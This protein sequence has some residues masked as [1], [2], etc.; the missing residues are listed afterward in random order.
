MSIQAR[1]IA[2]QARQIHEADR[3]ARFIALRI[4][5]S[6]CTVDEVNVGVESW[7]VVGCESPLAVRDAMR[8]L[9]QAPTQVVL[10]YGGD[11]S[12]LGADVLG[13]CAK[14]K[15]F[16]PDLWQIVMSLFRASQIDPRLV[17][18]RWLAELLIRYMPP[19]GY[20]PVLS[21]A[22]DDERAWKE[23]FAHVLGF[24][25]AVPSVADLFRWALDAGLR[26]RYLALDIDARGQVRDRLVEL[27]G[28]VARYVL[29]AVDCGRAD[30]LLVT[31]LLCEALKT[32]NNSLAAA[33]AQVAARLE[34][35]FG[36]MT[37]DEVAVNRLADAGESVF[38]GLGESEKKLVIE[39]F[40]ALFA[41]AKAEPLAGICPYG[42]LGL[43]TRI[44]EFSRAIAELSLGRADAA[45]AALNKYRWPMPGSTRIERARMALNLV[46]WL[47]AD[48]EL[49]NRTLSE[50]ASHYRD[51]AAWVDWARSH[52]LEGDD[53]PDLAAAYAHLR[54]VVRTRH[55]GFD[56]K[57]AA[58]L[59][60]DE[61]DGRQL[62]GIEFALDQCVAKVIEQG[63]GLLV[64]LDG[65]SMAVFLELTESLRARS[66]LDCYLADVRWPS[67]LA[68][69]PSTTEAS[70]TSL[71][72]GT[73]R[74][75]DASTE[76]TAFSQRPSLVQYSVS[77]KPPILFHKADLLDSSGISLSDSL[78]HAL[79]DSRQR[80]VG[81]VINA[82]DDHLAK[83]D[84]LRLRWTVD[85]F[86]A[87]DAILAEARSSDRTVIITSDHGHILDQ[88]TELRSS[89]ANAR[90]REPSLELHD[91]EVEL[92]GARVQAACGLD[93]VVLP[94]N[95]TI[96]YASKRNGYHGGCSP[97]EAIVPFATFRFAGTVGTPWVLQE[98]HKPAWWISPS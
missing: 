12:T 77:G 41:T 57:F 55:E 90:W 56:R 78:L 1:Q 67:L 14:R 82:V 50:L 58:S 25:Q 71:L 88:D 54:R 2:V 47:Q 35:V 60:Q 94:W 87:L 36:G 9:S 6:E 62:I 51:S 13:R 91:G 97:A 86:R 32:D 92:S 7:P 33:Q 24:Q 46:S 48:D 98:T 22:L 3:I 38:V 16:A 89:G 19:E 81:V 15:L 29:A 69:L 43:S 30:D 10:L 52:L 96:R 65:M 72:S 74:R 85:Q 93:R 61:T 53:S 5:P 49:G 20:S 8:R 84:Q 66:W 18:H 63:R 28:P 4:A 44:V 83:S 40:E 26:E 27:A 42:E 59:I 39:R 68:M 17:G 23:F 11:E 73:A 76:K 21:V 31:G 95:E 80:L 45:F 75:G 37:L 34:G 79:R 70:R 64:V